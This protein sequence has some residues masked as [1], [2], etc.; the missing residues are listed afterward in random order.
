MAR[1]DEKLRQLP[2]VSARKAWMTEDYE[3][4]L[5][6]RFQ[7]LIDERVWV[8]KAQDEV[9]NAHEAMEDMVKAGVQS[10]EA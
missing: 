5:P 3:N 7:R 9:T 8:E 4:Y 6:I 2:T 10:W 1:L